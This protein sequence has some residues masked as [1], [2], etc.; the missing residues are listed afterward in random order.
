MV[1]VGPPEAKILLVNVDGKHYALLESCSHRNCPL[2]KGRLIDN[3]VV[4]PCHGA[5]F[6]VRTGAPQKWP[7]GSID[8]RIPS[9]SIFKV[10]QEGSDLIIEYH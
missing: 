2:S 3:I 4:C 8:Y 6:D 10:R 7:Y 1:L 9:L 5:E